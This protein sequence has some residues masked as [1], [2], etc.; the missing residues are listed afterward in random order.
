MSIHKLWNFIKIFEKEEYA[1]QF[2]SGHLYLNRLSFFRD[3][4]SQEGKQD[5]SEAVSLWMQPGDVE[6]NLTLSGA[7]NIKI[8]SKDL[9]GPISIDYGYHADLHVLCLYAIHTYGFEEIYGEINEG[10]AGE[11]QRQVMI[12]DRCCKL[13][14]FAVITQAIKFRKMLRGVLQNRRQWFRDG[15]VRYYD[16]DIF[17]G[18]FAPHDAPF[19]KQKRFSYQKEYRFCLQTDTCGNEPLTINI[20][21]IDHICK[22]VDTAALNS[23]FTLQ[24]ICST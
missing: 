13:G 4:E 10:R 11:L 6:V 23:I 3:L 14:Q 15:L 1:D 2:I 21:S 18:C 24:R 16:E 17:S 7:G 5:A 22:K 20:G 8:T 12:D 9:G 19:Y